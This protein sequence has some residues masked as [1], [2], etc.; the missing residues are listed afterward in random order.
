MSRSKRKRRKIVRKIGVKGL[1]G[2]ET[3]TKKGYTKKRLYREGTTWEGDYAERGH[4]RRTDY[5]GRGLHGEGTT[6]R[7]DYTERKLYEEGTT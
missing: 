2:E 5:T 7:G 3:H 4:T 1:H 6:R